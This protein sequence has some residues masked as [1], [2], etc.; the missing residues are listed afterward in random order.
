MRKIKEIIT[1]EEFTMEEFWAAVNSFPEIVDGKK[2]KK[3]INAFF[4]KDGT[5][6][7]KT[8]VT[9]DDFQ[10][11]HDTHGFINRIIRLHIR[12]SKAKKKR[13][14]H[15]QH[16]KDKKIS[17]HKERKDVEEIQI[18]P[19]VVRNELVYK[20]NQLVREGNPATKEL[21][22]QIREQINEIENTS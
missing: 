21:R 15:I 12:M 11:W 7:V 5:P 20:Y 9:D 16:I 6:K 14:D 8:L 18:N 4:K 22:E 1:G 2:H 10:T 3:N 13:N 17:V 19:A